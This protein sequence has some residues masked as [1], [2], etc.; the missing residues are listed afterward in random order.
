MCSGWLQVVLYVTVPEGVS[1]YVSPFVEWSLKGGNTGKLIFVKSD[2]QYVRNELKRLEGDQLGLKQFVS[3]RMKVTRVKAPV[4]GFWNV[5]M[6]HSDYLFT[7]CKPLYDLAAQLEISPSEGACPAKD[8]R[9]REQ[10]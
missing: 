9:M 7:A 8:E 6:R 3:E 5:A 2:L 4:R 1:W 10:Y